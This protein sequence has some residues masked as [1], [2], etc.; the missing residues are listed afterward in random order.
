[1]KS[2]LFFAITKAL[3]WKSGMLISPHA[4]GN[5]F[6]SPLNVLFIK[7]KKKP[8]FFLHTIST[9]ITYTLQVQILSCLFV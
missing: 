8:L 5:S 7:R 4:A 3:T 6:V 1:M 9:Q 2:D